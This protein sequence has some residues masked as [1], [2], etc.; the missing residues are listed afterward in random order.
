MKAISI[1]LLVIFITFVYQ[2]KIGNFVELDQIENQDVESLVVQIEALKLNRGHYALSI[3]NGGSNNE[4]DALEGRIALLEN[5]VARFM[6][7]EIRSEQMN[8][9]LIFLAAIGWLLK[10]VLEQPLKNLSSLVCR[11]AI[12]L[13]AN[14]FK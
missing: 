14:L 3:S 2:F 4:L 8:W 7:A 1:I 9:K 6:T 12:K 5:Q 10:V 11:Y 13:K